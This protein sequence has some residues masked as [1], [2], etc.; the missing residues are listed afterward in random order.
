MEVVEGTD[1][2][3]PIAGVNPLLAGVR[4]LT[5][6]ADEATDSEAIFRALARE[7]LSV[8]GAEEV[9]RRGHGALFA[10]LNAGRVEAARLSG[11]AVLPLAELSS[12]LDQRLALLVSGHRGKRSICVLTA[13][14]E[15]KRWKTG[16]C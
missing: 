9:F 16:A 5:L 14:C 2:S 6:L 13:L 12:R 4:R 1:T 3:R 7:L 15:R 11:G 10:G 8:P